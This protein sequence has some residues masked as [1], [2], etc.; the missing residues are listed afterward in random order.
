MFHT[1]V[2]TFGI[3]FI[4]KMLCQ[5]IHIL[6]GGGDSFV[7]CFLSFRMINLPGL[8]RTETGSQDMGFSVKKKQISLDWLGQ[9]G[10]PTIIST[11][12]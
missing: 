7:T 2:H 6:S 8:P 9:I 3:F 11:H 5:I 4:L 12:W 10:H 1:D